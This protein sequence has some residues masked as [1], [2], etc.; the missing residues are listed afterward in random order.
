M[1][2]LYQPVFVSS[3]VYRVTGYKP[4]H[5]LS[6]ERIGPVMDICRALGWLDAS[7]YRESPAATA[8]ELSVFHDPAYVAAVRSVS[9]SGQVTAEQRRRFHL[10]TM[11]NPVF[12]GLWQRAATSVGGSVLAAR[13]A[14]EG[15]VA[16]HPAGGTHH[17]RRDRASGFCY[18]NDP[19]F[20]MLEFLNAGLARVAYLDLDAHHGDGV[21]AAFEADPRT[22]CISVHEAGRWPGTG[23]THTQS[24]RNFAVPRRFADADLDGL[25][26]A[27][28]IPELTAFRPDA[29]VITCGADALSGDPL[30]SMQLS[31]TGLWRAVVAAVRTSPRVVVLGGGGYNPWTTVRCWAGLWG[32]LNGFAMPEC[33][34]QQVRNLLRSFA[35]DLV[36]DEDIKPEWLSTIADTIPSGA[37]L[38]EVT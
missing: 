26:A 31:N 7:N 18:F 32:R 30:S 36:D 29:L 17:G 24:A 9:E 23:Q 21:E 38:E 11:E 34:P 14:M 15:R 25:M 13:L 33:L 4:P 2:H 28:I 16:Y 22:L 12:P 20:A 27:E 1:T 19:V 8:E 3:D 10:G 37:I 35:C 6:I 5:P